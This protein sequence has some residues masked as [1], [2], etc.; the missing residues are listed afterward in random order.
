MILK[1]TD[2]HEVGMSDYVYRCLKCNKIAYEA[3]EGLYKCN[4][5]GFEWEI[6]SFE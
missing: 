3:E 5:C 4:A 1:T 6:M 2:N